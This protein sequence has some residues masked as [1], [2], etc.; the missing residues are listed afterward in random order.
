MLA[1]LKHSFND[2]RHLPSGGGGGNGGGGGGLGSSSA[3]GRLSSEPRLSKSDI[4]LG[5]EKEGSSCHSCGQ[6]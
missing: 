4:R 3:R 5:K 6:L 1:H 2:L